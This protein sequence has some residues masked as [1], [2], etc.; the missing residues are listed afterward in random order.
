M[1]LGEILTSVSGL[2]RSAAILLAFQVSD[3]LPQTHEKVKVSMRNE[4][5]HS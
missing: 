2:V 3:Q 4:G 5:M 1:D